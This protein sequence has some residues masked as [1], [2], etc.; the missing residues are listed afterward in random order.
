VE[1]EVSL[2]TRLAD[3][4]RGL[5]SGP[6]PDLDGTLGELTTA[7]TASVP[8]AQH[9]GITV[10]TRQKKVETAASTHRVAVLLDDIQRDHG[11]GPCLSA[12]WDQQIIR[13]DDMASEDR[14]P[15]YCQDALAHT[16]I[17]SVLSYRLFVDHDAMGALNFYADA[18]HA[19]DDEAIEMGL[20]W[21]THTALAWTMVRRDKE[22]RSALAS[23]DIIGQ[24]KGVIMERYT[25]DSVQAFDM[26]KRLSQDSN[27]PVAEIA[28]RLVGT[29]GNS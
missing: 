7:A 14:W 22:F 1:A 29:L 27:V 24:A 18:P 26:L 12:A 2:A 21:A 23:R 19:F 8:G 10:A 5:Q 28:K 6:V 17:R 25:V 15:C 20:L 16:S 11:E 9:A 13:I 4:I 3:A